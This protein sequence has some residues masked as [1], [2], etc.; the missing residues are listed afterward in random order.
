MNGEILLNKGANVNIVTFI[1]FLI[2]T[3]DII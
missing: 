2:R 1:Y 3:S